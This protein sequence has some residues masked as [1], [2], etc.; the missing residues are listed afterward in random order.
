MRI[1]RNGL[2]DRDRKR[3]VDL[4]ESGM[5]QSSIAKRFSCS[6]QPIQAIIRDYKR[7]KDY[8]NGKDI[9]RRKQA[10]EAEIL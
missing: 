6:V 3:I 2:T 5:P 9:E 4:F 10:K 1:G 8:E 7:H